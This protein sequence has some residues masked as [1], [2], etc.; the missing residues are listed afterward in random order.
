MNIGEA[1]A[2]INQFPVGIHC[3]RIDCQVPASQ[4]L[5]NGYLGRGVKGEAVIT[6]AGFSFR[7]CQ[8]IFFAALRMQ[9]HRKVFADRL[10]TETLKFV[11]C[12]AHDAPVPLF[13]GQAKLLVPNRTTDEIKFH[14]AILSCMRLDCP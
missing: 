10:I 1:V 3:H 14:T 2:W 9:K 4:V 8:C 13:D 6:A 12:R 11:R 5:F 7:A